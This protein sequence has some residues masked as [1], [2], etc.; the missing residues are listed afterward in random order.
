MNCSNF[1]RAQTYKGV[2]APA[3]TQQGQTPTSVCL[4]CSAL[5][6]FF[7][8]AS[9][10]SS[11]LTAIKIHMLNQTSTKPQ[12]YNNCLSLTYCML[13]TA[14][15]L[16]PQPSSLC[17]ILWSQ[18]DHILLS[19][20]T[21]FREENKCQIGSLTYTCVSDHPFTAFYTMENSETKITQVWSLCQNPY[22]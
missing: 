15:A 6:S 19:L 18:N 7:S 9:L 12:L 22:G 20:N 8:S 21:T 1:P 10:S 4:W 14:L 2:S 3:L 11:L 5:Y 16:Q 13:A 17:E